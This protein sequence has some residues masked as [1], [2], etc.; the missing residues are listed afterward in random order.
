[1]SGRCLTDPLDPADD[2]CDI[3]YGEY[4]Q[5]HLVHAKGRRHPICLQCALRLSGVRSGDKAPRNGNPK[6]VKRRRH[7]LKNDANK[8][9]PDFIY[10]DDPDAKLLAKPAKFGANLPPPTHRSPPSE[11]P[12]D[13]AEESAESTSSPD[14]DTK[15]KNKARAQRSTDSEEE[16]DPV[17][18]LAPVIANKGTVLDRIVEDKRQRAQR[19][20][21]EVAD[22]HPE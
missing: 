13:L 16:R 1:M 14:T 2:V 21:Q 20:A 8:Q 17:E 4:C 22:R 19:L 5:E 10:F 18:L 11:S 7:E 15:P 3:C 9:R 12:E 6:T